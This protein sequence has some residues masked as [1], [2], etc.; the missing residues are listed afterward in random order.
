[1]ETAMVFF[2]MVRFLVEI[3]G[4]MILVMAGPRIYRVVKEN[5]GRATDELRDRRK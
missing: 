3:F 1:M 4:W 5:V 2:R